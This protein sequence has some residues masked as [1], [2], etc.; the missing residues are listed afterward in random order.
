METIEYRTK[1]KTT[2]GD[3][4]WQDEPDKRQW[5]DP[6]TGLACLIVRN[7]GAWCGYVGVPEGHP[8]HGKG[9]DDTGLLEV[10]GGITFA[11]AC[12]HGAEDSA[13]CHKPGPG[14]PDTV[15]WIGFDCNHAFDLDPER[16]A[17]YRDRGDLWKPMGD[18]VYRDINYVTDEVTQ[19]A[20]Q[21]ANICQ[22]S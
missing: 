8:A 9:Y 20:A 10:H 5:Q 17:R 4:P 16:V 14:E 21:L 3:G 13:I 11:G 1:D 2:W 6:A 22:P 12:S 7:H 15:W 18:E 19:L